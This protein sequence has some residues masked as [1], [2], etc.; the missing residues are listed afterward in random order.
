MFN[1]EGTSFPMMCQDRRIGVRSAGHIRSQSPQCSVV[2]SAR[3][4]PGKGT[5]LSCCAVYA[6]LRTTSAENATCR[7]EEEL[8]RIRSVK[9]A[10]TAGGSATLSAPHLSRNSGNRAIETAESKSMTADGPD[11][12]R[13]DPGRRPEEKGSK[14]AAEH[15]YRGRCRGKIVGAWSPLLRRKQKTARNAPSKKPETR[16]RSLVPYLESPPSEKPRQRGSTKRSRCPRALFVISSKKATLG[17]RSSQTEQG[18]EANKRAERPLCRGVQPGRVSVLHPLLGL[19]RL[20]YG[21]PPRCRK[22]A[23]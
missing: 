7:R 16:S 21:A 8:S 9:N 12:S 14:E 15:P 17:P 1:A 5:A 22:S 6:C 10:S 2:S 19:N 3:A 23:C 4:R 11:S 20:L 13:P 18:I